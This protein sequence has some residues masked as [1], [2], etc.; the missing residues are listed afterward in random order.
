MAAYSVYP[1]RRKC[2]YLIQKECITQLV[3][4]SVMASVSAEEEQDRISNSVRGQISSCRRYDSLYLKVQYG[5]YK[6]I[7]S[8]QS[9]AAKSP[10]LCL[11]A[12]CNQMDSV[13]CVA[14]PLPRLRPKER[15]SVFL[16]ICHD[17]WHKAFLTEE[18]GVVM[19]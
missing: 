5:G 3:L 8:T 15:N 7:C 9:Q 4:D 10:T 17:I 12:L 19:M 14:P 11:C 16:I 2:H 6:T 1:L 18:D 13:V